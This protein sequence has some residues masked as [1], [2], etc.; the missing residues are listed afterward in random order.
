MNSPWSL[1][2]APTGELY[3]ADQNNH[4]IREVSI[5]G[6]IST[7]AGTGISGFAGDKG[8]ATAAQ[9]NAP[10]SVA[11]DVAGNLYIADS[12]N[13]R[14]RKVNAQTGV[15]DTVAGND[16][17]S[18]SGDDGPAN[19]AGL[20]GPYSLAIDGTGSL[21]IA[22]V[23][24]N[25]IRKVTANQAVLNFPPMRVGRVAPAQK[26]KLEN[27]GNAPLHPASVLAI[28]NS[29][30]DDIATTCTPSTTLDPLTQC[31]IG[32][33]FAPTQIG[34]LVKGEVDVKSDASNS[35]GALTVQGQ[36]LTIDPSSVG[37]ASSTNPSITGASVTF[38]VTVTSA[39]T[40]PTGAVSLLDGT[41]TLGVT[42]LGPAGTGSFKISTLTGGQHSLTASYAGDT[43]NSSGVSPI[44]VQ[45][46]KDQVA[47]TNTTLSSSATRLDAG[48][49]LKL[50]AQ[51]AVQTAG[52]GNGTIGG[53]V[54]FM[55]GS[56][57]L[58]TAPVTNGSA[59]LM[60]SL[61]TGSHRVLAVYSGDTNFSTSTSA[62]LVETV[63]IASTRIAIS[64][65]NNPSNAGAPLYLSAVVLST[66][67]IAGGQVTFFD[68]VLALGTA[69]LDAQGMAGITSAG[70]QWTVGAH[71]LT[72]TYAG[73]QNDSA[74]NSL[75]LLE[76][77]Q[78]AKSSVVLSSSLNPAGYGANLTL[79]ALA[80]SNGATPSGPMQFFDGATLL[81]S[82]A[83]DA[84]G[85]AQFTTNSLTIGAHELH[86]AFSG[87]KFNASA[88]SPVLTQTITQTNIAALLATGQNPSIFSNPLT[89]TASITGNGSQPSGT[90][91]FLDGSTSLGQAQLDA[92]GHAQIVNTSLALGTHTLT[93]VYAGDQYH[94]A[95]TSGAVS[96]TIV[97]GTSTT[98]G[99]S[100]TH[101]FAG[102]PLQWT[103]TVRGAS[104]QPVGGMV[105]FV[106]GS[107]VIARVTPSAAG[108]A[109]V[110]SS[111]MTP[112]QHIVV[113][114]YEGDA[115]NAPSNSTPFSVNIDVAVTSTALVTSANPVNSGAPV[116]LQA[117][118][119]GNGG[120]PTGPVTFLDGAIVLAV[121]PVGV[122]GVASMTTATLAPGIHQLV[123]SYAGDANDQPSVS[124]TIAE[125]IVQRTA[126]IV[127][128]S[129]NPSLLGDTVTLTVTASN[130]A[131]GAAP[132]GIVNLTDGTSPAGSATLNNAGTATFVLSSLTVGDHTFVINYAGDNANSP[133]TSTPLIQKVSLRPTTNTFTTSATSITAGQPMV[134]VSVVQG[135]GSRPPTGLVTFASGSTVLGSAQINVAGVASIS[136]MPDE[137]LYNVVASY[138]GDALYAPSASVNINIVVGPTVAF[139]LRSTPG[140][141][142]MKSGQHA[143]L[144][145]DLTI[146]KNF[147]DTL[148]LGCAGL[149]ASATC[150]FSTNQIAVSGGLPKSLT[151]TVD[152]GAPLG[153]GAS[154]S[155]AHTT[156]GT[157]LACLLPLG[158]LSM[159]GLRRRAFRRPLGLVCAL[160]ALG[161]VGTLS[162]CGNS[163]TMVDTPPGQY[164]FQIVGTGNKTGATQT[165][166]V[167]LE[168]TR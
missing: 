64:S 151:V 72:A 98:L 80:S 53:S 17:E 105:S 118:V 75:P 135:A 31:T 44:L 47:A 70:A 71:S 41:S 2:V 77:I 140:S 78:L 146:A 60:T 54:A 30:V 90:V 157:M 111:S 26:Q 23:F 160:L 106:D 168:V 32:A 102:S 147:T 19:Q 65:N 153:A 18:F 4:V 110:T 48:A 52:A 166:I 10:A 109:Q 56:A 94:A 138:A 89:L 99:A 14:V 141:L 119:S 143:D 74:S 13:N 92:N 114:Q 43:S 85:T 66:G 129:A 21:Y 158:A 50:T 40:T 9:F 61:S 115:S 34:A 132:S 86:A 38:T 45:V 161:A 156:T 96:E 125:Q 121:Q 127:V 49:P 112:G 7:V 107:S 84:T 79:T 165:V 164:T 152:T 130:G 35:P 108:I 5:G 67:G 62:P 117:T 11:I 8:P 149:P 68:G 148:A 123:A 163:F 167:H 36:V 6:T 3:I 137:G 37:I 15:V 29:K 126:L 83:L 27:D 16:S 145:L 159:L 101:S 88:N 28:N 144:K 12:G 116:T 46:V 51:V 22:D 113:A 20:Y 82:A 69:T 1:T 87:D 133:G 131:A 76:N 55:D 120:M 136:I 57:Q 142:S 128:S 139:L 155:L 122:N 93:A 124:A 162:G 91:T 154:A 134:L 103:A 81:G 39:G 150:T 24:H 63:D 33:S 100:A 104:S 25:R 73:D 58:G 42:Q 59:A 97:Q 95:V